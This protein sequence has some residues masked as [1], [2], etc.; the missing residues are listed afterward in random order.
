[1]ADLRAV[2]A[3]NRHAVSA[4]AHAACAFSPA[5]WTTPRMPGKWS[6]G[7]VTEHVTLAYEQSGRM[8]HG[9]FTGK[10]MP[11]YRQLLARWIGLPQLF[12]RGDYG[13]GS[14]QAPDFIHPSASP[15]SAAAILARL[16]AAVHDLEGCLAGTD[17]RPVL[18]DHPIFGR[19]P[20]ADLLHFLSIH[21]NHHLPQLSASAVQPHSAALDSSTG[22]PQL[23]PPFPDLTPSITTPPYPSP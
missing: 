17:A 10:A 13:K 9:T 6:P 8:L 23:L 3:S 19:L 12:K 2:I 14:F 16:E 4:F 1:M 7:Q 18:V 20:L 22:T 21:T 5:Q 15:P 11:W